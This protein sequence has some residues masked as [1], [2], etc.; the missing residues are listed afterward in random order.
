[1]QQKKAWKINGF[2]GLLLIIVFVVL[3][4]YAFVKEMWV[5][6]II[7]VVLAFIPFCGMIIVQSNKSAVIT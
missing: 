7:S 4:I 1:M 2:V 5:L 6:G 3:A